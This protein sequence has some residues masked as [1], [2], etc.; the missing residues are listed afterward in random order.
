MLICKGTGVAVAWCPVFR[1][2]LL[3]SSG[4]PIFYMAKKKLSDFT[5]ASVSSS[6]FCLPAALRISLTSQPGGASW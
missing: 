5:V 6:E 1:T 2:G 4:L 3:S